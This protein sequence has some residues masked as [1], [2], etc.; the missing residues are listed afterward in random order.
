MA[1]CQC[2]IALRKCRHD[3]RKKKGVL[4]VGRGY[5]TVGGKVT[6]RLSVIVTVEKKLPASK[7]S[8]ADLIPKTIEGVETDVVVSSPFKVPTPMRAMVAETIYSDRHRPCPA[9]VS[10]GHH[11]IT[12]GTFGCRVFDKT[13]KEWLILSNNH[14]LANS[15][16]A[17]I[18]DPIL[19]PGPYDGGDLGADT[20]GTLYK[21][22]PITFGGG[23][24]PTK[25]PISNTITKVLNRGT[26]TVGSSVIFQAFTTAGASA[27]ENLVDCALARPLSVTDIMSTVLD[28]GLIGGSVNAELG[29]SIEKTGRTTGH[30]KGTILQTDVT[31][32]VSYGEG[33]V[34][35]FTDQLLAGAMSAGGDSGSAIVDG[36]NRLVGLLFAGSDEYT[37][38]NRSANVLQQLN[39][40]I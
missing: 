34:A 26:K 17:Q 20:I 14:V 4:S 2:R 21:F 28:I 12:A 18:G 22:V 19:Q 36:S 7:L 32:N 11:S 25:C 39:I 6:D 9:G 35:T 29:T 37:I 10:I 24:T 1:E 8:A 40:E 16:N 27:T 13:T 15:N 23:T 38:M 30:T 3:L 5:K 31:V 33:K